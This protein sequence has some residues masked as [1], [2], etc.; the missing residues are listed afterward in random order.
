[1]IDLRFLK[2]INVQGHLSPGL[3]PWGGLK[4]I[5]V[6]GHLSPGLIPW[7]GLK[8]INVQGHLSPGMIPWGKRFRQRT[9]S[10]LLSA[11]IQIF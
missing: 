3:I 10:W 4:G 8:G 1:M 5:N 11:Q 9:E 2:G 6:Q 7:G